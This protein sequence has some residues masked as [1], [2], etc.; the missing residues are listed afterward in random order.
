MIPISHVHNNQPALPTIDC[1]YL[2][3]LPHQSSN[4]AQLKTPR[5]K[6]LVL[7]SCC[8]C[9][10]LHWLLGSF[11]PEWLANQQRIGEERDGPERPSVCT[12]YNQMNLVQRQCH[13]RAQVPLDPSL[14]WRSRPCSYSYASPEPPCQEGV[15][16]LLWHQPSWHGS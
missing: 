16:L 15:L 14:Q 1:P 2:H 3:I 4:L 12:A 6:K 9:C 8:C 10:W 5:L 7:A 11:Y 13:F